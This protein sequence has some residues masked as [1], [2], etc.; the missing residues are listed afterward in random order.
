M[1][2]NVVDKC[3]KKAP[4]KIIKS[5]LEVMTN[6]VSYNYNYTYSYEYDYDYNDNNKSWRFYIKL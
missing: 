4:Y 2:M 6:K 1:F 3:K 5:D